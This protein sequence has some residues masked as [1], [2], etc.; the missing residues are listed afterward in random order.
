MARTRTLLRDGADP[1]AMPVAHVASPVERAAGAVVAAEVRAL[2]E[3]AI[4]PWSRATHELFPAPARARA[5]DLLRLG[6]MLAVQPRFIGDS[7]AV[8]D[9]WEAVVRFAVERNSGEH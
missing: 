8:V 4:L 5:V 7:Q 6:H 9:C 2:L 1:H 3:R